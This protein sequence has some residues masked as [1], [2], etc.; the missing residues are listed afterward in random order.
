M[1]P[2]GSDPAENYRKIRSELALHST[3]LTAKKELIVLNK[4]DLDPD[5]EIVKDIKN[6][7]GVDNVKT[8]SAVSGEGLGELNETLWKMVK[9]KLDEFNSD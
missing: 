2:D 8:I 7:L 1:P 6:A 4:I 9:G 3:E 5:K